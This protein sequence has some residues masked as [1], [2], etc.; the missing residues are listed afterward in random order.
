MSFNVYVS[1]RS[2]IEAASL[3]T[4]HS[5]EC[6]AS[7][8]KPFMWRSSKTIYIFHSESFWNE[9]LFDSTTLHED[10][11]FQCVTQVE[12]EWDPIMATMLINPQIDM[13]TLHPI[14]IKEYIEDE[15]LL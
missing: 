9:E 3:A 12:W 15:L 2:R 4:R 1:I 14:L 5:G 8:E 6:Y 7:E 13:R 10:T 11:F